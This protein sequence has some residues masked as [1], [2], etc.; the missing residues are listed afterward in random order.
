M[1]VAEW[2]FPTSLAGA[3]ISIAN[4]SLLSL[5]HFCPLFPLS[6]N[7]LD[8]LLGATVQKSNYSTKKK[9]ITYKAA[10]EGDE[11]KAISGLDILDNHQVN[12]VSS[13]VL[14]AVTGYLSLKALF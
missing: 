4:P 1:E 2:S 6:S 3:L 13:L 10:E 8:S 14:A 5:S 9:I 7:Q 11:V 12:F